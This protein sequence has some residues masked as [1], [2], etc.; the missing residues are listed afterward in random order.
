M[1]GLYKTAMI[2]GESYPNPDA[3]ISASGSRIN[4]F[5]GSLLWAWLLKSFRC[6]IDNNDS[7]TDTGIDSKRF[8]T[9]NKQGD[10]LF[11]V[12]CLKRYLEASIGTQKNIC[13]FIIQSLFF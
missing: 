8:G 5:S 4:V 11:G 10:G 9:G 13:C 1:P 3:G 7:A 12:T 2:C 6:I